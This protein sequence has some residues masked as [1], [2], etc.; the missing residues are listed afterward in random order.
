[1]SK[2]L[3]CRQRHPSS[4]PARN[5][6]IVL[7]HA[8]LHSAQKRTASCELWVWQRPFSRSLVAYTPIEHDKTQFDCWQIT[9][10]LPLALA[11]A[12]SVAQLVHRL[13][14]RRCAYCRSVALRLRASRK[15]RQQIKAKCRVPHPPL[16]T[17]PTFARLDLLEVS[18]W[19]QMKS[20]VL[21]ILPSKSFLSVFHAKQF[22]VTFA[23]QVPPFPPSPTL[24]SYRWFG[25]VLW[26]LWRWTEPVIRFGYNARLSWSCWQTALVE[27][28]SAGPQN[29]QHHFIWH[30]KTFQMELWH[31]NTNAHTQSHS[32]TL[33]S[34]A[35]A[36]VSSPNEKRASVP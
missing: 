36:N 15:S 35:V 16:T 32:R 29:S 31:T 27:F 9:K 26:W 3:Q 30:F 14:V 34:N 2:W 24:L 21:I 12:L 25:Q 22:P 1:M 7:P 20:N 8:S 13:A 18:T 6:F 17:F 23:W 33:Y 19:P 10:E 28:F 4:S 5:V 11:L